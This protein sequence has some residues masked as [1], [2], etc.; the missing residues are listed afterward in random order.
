MALTVEDGSIVTGAN[1][2]VT[3]AAARS[4]AAA[5]G[6]TVPV[7]DADL[8]VM[9]IKAMDYLES[10]RDQF[11]GDSVERDQP[12]SFPRSG[13]VIE[14]WEW[15]KTEIPRHVISAQL[16]V[17]LEVA[18]GID[19]FNP[20]LA[21]QPVIKRRVEGAIELAYASPSAGGMKIS[22]DREADVLLRLLLRK[23]GLFAIRA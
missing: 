2:Y 18:A 20:P 21:V 14:G 23:S 16:A 11:L 5:R 13:V 9:V 8:E 15:S 19:P 10:H 1:S 12:L 7:A 3:L 6:A 22:K 17:L 4:Y